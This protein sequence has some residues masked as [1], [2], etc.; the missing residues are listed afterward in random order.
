MYRNIYSHANSIRVLMMMLMMIH[1][2]PA[3]TICIP[4]INTNAAYT[5]RLLSQ[6][7]FPILILMLHTPYACFHNMYSHY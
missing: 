7:V 3:F 5:L 2:T 4:T 1:P 6:Y